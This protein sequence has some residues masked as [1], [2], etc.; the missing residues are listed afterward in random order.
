MNKHSDIEN[1]NLGLK[2]KYFR[3]MK[4][5]MTLQDH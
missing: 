2:V 3:S 4:K 1:C 5:L